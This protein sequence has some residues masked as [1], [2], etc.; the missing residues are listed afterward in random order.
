MTRIPA[1]VFCPDSRMVEY[2]ICA[3]NYDSLIHT[4]GLVFA[5]SANDENCVKF[6][7]K[8]FYFTL[9]KLKKKC[10]LLR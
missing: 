5:V 9:S 1:F 8:R 4:N 2:E 10:D 6:K 3:D 7:S